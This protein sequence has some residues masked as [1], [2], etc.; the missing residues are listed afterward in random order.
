MNT[1]INV[2]HHRKSDGAIQT[3]F[4]HCFE[5]AKIARSNAEKF[6]LA[7]MGEI[8][9]LLHDLGKNS[10]QFQD[11]IKSAIGLIE[12]DADNYVDSTAN[13]GKIDH[14]TSGAQY[15]W[16]KFNNGDKIN[17]LASNIIA[18]CICSHHSGL[19]DCINPEGLDLFG[20]RMN[21][22][23]D[24]TNF[25]ETVENVEIEIIN[26]V[27]TIFNSIEFKNEIKNI[28]NFVYSDLQSTKSGITANFK[29]GLIVK[30]LFSCLID[31]DRID[32]CNFEFPNKASIRN[33][34]Y[35]LNWDILIKKLDNKISSFKQDSAVNK[36]RNDVYLQCK[37]ASQRDVNIY[38]L[39]VPT[40]GSKTFSS[41]AFA[42]QHAK[43]HNLKRII[44]VAP[45]TAIIDQ[46]ADDMRKIFEQDNE[47]GSVML[48]VHSNIL[49]T[50]ETWKTKLLSENWDAPIIFTT[51]VKLLNILFSSGT[52]DARIMHQLS[53]SV[54]I[55]DEVQSTP[56]RVVHMFNNAMNFLS[57]FCN[58]TIVLCT[59][60]QPPLGNVNVGL[61]SI[62][63]PTNREIMNDVQNLF[64]SLKRVQTYDMTRK[65]EWDIEDMADL[66][67][68]EFEI[69]GN[70]LVIT[71]TKN[72]AKELYLR[73]KNSFQGDVYHLSTSMCPAHRMKIISE[74]KSKLINKQP[75]VCI[76]T[77]LI[78]AGINIDFGTVIRHIA[79]LDSI[80]QAAG[81]CNR[82][83]KLSCGRLIIVNPEQN[84]VYKKAME[85]LPDILKSISAT[86]R[87]LREF[88]NNP[89]RFENDLI[90]VKSLNKFYE[91]YYYNRADDMKYSVV[92]SSLI[93]RNGDLLSLLSDNKLSV[94]SYKQQNNSCSPY[95]IN[96]SFSTA[97]KIFEAID[98]SAEGVIVPFEEGIEYINKLCSSKDDIEIKK[99][100]R[101]CQRFSVN[102]FPNQKEK[103]L[104][105][106]CIKETQPQSGIMYVV[107]QNYSLEF[108]VTSD[109]IPM[110]S[111]II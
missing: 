5:T 84:Q 48:E 83:G 18:L 60:T 74:I 37:N 65:E 33:N 97:S 55:I 9:G 49:P 38:Q 67:K 3:V 68:K 22:S 61:G 110:P 25:V 39:T 86:E 35:Y 28:T 108:G 91:Y 111:L 95:N 92:P 89:N 109:S 50:K 4:E 81:R 85:K 101:K 2:A 63:F 24:T 106:N 16:N 19:I 56:I 1:N 51:F 72:C 52:S 40:G 75:I 42:L 11:Y 104:K 87:V 78:E 90:G 62:C 21:K 82:D 45:Y 31:A 23:Y 102:L 69:S 7:N 105:K 41:M 79:G 64:N 47:F 71:N 29:L 99:I 27:D 94:D 103:L 10:K 36:I 96:Q 59:A 53:E 14:S 13:K 46:N 30:I 93:N 26:K 43:K 77:Q 57:K 58:S 98:S 107:P 32:S 70:V 17:K 76:S 73:C 8:C 100:L 66:L 54:I 6:G 80:T 44:Y 88:K 12:Q 20:K 34:G 15:I